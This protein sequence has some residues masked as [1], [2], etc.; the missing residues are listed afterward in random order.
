MTYTFKSGGQIES[1]FF[2]NPR[3]G[4]LSTTASLDRE[5][6][7]SYELTVVARDNPEYG[8]AKEDEVTVIVVVQDIDDNPPT[9]DEGLFFIDVSE[10]VNRTTDLIMVIVLFLSPFV[11]NPCET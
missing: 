10:D 6:Q 7:A 11:G 2:L 9:F 4:E 5:L 8:P 1:T 3:T